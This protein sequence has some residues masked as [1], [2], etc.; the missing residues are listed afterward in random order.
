[1]KDEKETASRSEDEVEIAEYDR[2]QAIAK[3]GKFAAYTAPAL[4]VLLS[5]KTSDANCVAS[6]S[7]G[8]CT[9]NSC[10][11]PPQGIYPA[12]DSWK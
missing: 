7:D 9:G 5:A 8:V 6:N 12:C 11:P 1:M 10:T 4:L 2:R 3:I